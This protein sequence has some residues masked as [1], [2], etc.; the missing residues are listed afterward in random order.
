M[1]LEE[2]DNDSGMG[3]KR[4]GNEIFAGKD[5]NT[6]SAVLF[7]VYEYHGDNQKRIVE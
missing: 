3:K 6:A 1:R 2:H 4:G 7:P 5:E